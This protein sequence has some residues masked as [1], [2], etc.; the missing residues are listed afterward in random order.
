MATKE[1]RRARREARNA[2][3]KAKHEAKRAESQAKYEARRA[4]LQ[5]KLDAGK[6]ARKREKEARKHSKLS[7]DTDLKADRLQEIRDQLSSLDGVATLLGRREI[8]DLPNILWDDEQI[9]GALQGLYGGGQGLLVAT[10]RRMVFVDKKLIGNRVK[11]E[12]FPYDSVSSIQYELKMLFATVKVFASGNK[13]EIEQVMPKALAR[14]F[15]EAVRALISGGDGRRV[16]DRDGVSVPPE[17][18]PSG[19]EQ[20]ADALERLADLRDRGLLSDEEF[21]EQKRSLLSKTTAA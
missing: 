4:E 1:E 8:N 19:V 18:R 7:L 5:G 10:D 11:V 21:A 16:A 12:D 13:A 3:L 9:K 17:S 15:C 6:E 2:E 20:M 14:S